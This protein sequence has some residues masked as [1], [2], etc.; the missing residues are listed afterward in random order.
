M[1]FMRHPVTEAPEGMCYGRLDL[2][3]GAGARAQIA[4]AC[5]TC[6][7]I[8]RIVSSPAQRCAVLAKALAVRD[9]AEINYDSRFWEMNFGAWEGLLWSEIPRAQSDPWAADYWNNAPP[10]GESFADVHA[11]VGAALASTP[12]DALVVA[13]AGVIRAAR[14]ILENAT[15]DEI[16]AD[17][18]PFATPISFGRRAA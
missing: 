17:P 7:R 8:V 15:L 9:G 10:E 18:I 13:H 16:W 12:S 14:M 6:P 1:I 11:R 5:E 3:L 4:A 2:G